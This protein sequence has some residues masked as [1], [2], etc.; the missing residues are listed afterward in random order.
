MA[1]ITVLG[2]GRMGTALC[3]PLLDRGHDVRIVGTHLDT[4]W[5]EELRRSSTHPGLGTALPRGATYAT[6]DGLADSLRGSDGV[7][8]GVSSA[9]IRWAGRTLGELLAPDTRLAMVTKGLEWADGRFATM[10][11]VFVS[12]LP[13]ALGRSVAPVSISGPCLAGELARRVE[14]C[15]VMSGPDAGQVEWWAGLVA[16][17]YYH[18][19]VAADARGNQ[20]ATAL[21]NAYAIALGIVAGARG[22]EEQTAPRDVAMQATANFNAEAA[23]FAQSAVE[24]DRLVRLEG[25]ETRSVMGLSGVGDLLV[26]C[27]GRNH[28]F[29]AWL[30][31]GLPLAEVLRR[32]EGVS[33]EG[34]EAVRE[35]ARALPAFETA[36]RISRAELPLARHLVDVLAGGSPGTIPFDRFDP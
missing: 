22:V 20:L 31:A 32:M 13:A 3:V 34:V 12:A 33:L 11:E 30:G 19:R 14:T 7:V 4:S 25:G 28:R 2:A 18:V 24:I 17:P 36:G 6:I 21:K 8:L 5:I 29:G 23:T 15:V 35:L 10:T 26:T 16:T 27:H 1:T 9:G